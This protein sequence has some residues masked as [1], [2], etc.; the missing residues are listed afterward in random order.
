MNYDELYIKIAI[1]YMDFEWINFLTKTK[2]TQQLYSTFINEWYKKKIERM[3][4]EQIY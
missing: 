4:F 1:Y 3:V 2:T